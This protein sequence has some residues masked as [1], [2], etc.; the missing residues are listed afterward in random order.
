MVAVSNFSMGINLGGRQ[1]PGPTFS[2]FITHIISIILVFYDTLD[3]ETQWLL[4]GNSIREY[5]ASEKASG[6]LLSN[7]KTEWCQEKEWLR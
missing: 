6:E 3:R 7:K 4:S 5:K 1:F 2:N